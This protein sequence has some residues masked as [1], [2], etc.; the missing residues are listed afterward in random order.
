MTAIRL[1]ASLKGV[2]LRVLA[3]DIS[4]SAGWCL[5][6]GEKGVTPKILGSGTVVNPTGLKEMGKYPWNYIAGA[7]LMTSKLIELIEANTCDVIVIEETNMGRNRY[8]QK[9]LEFLHCLLLDYFKANGYVPAEKVFYIN[10][11]DWRKILGIHM[12]KVDKAQNIKVKRLKRIN[13]EESKAILK[14]AGLRGK[15]T[16]KHLAIRWANETYGLELR[17][18]DDDIADALALGTSYYMGVRFCDG[19]N[20]KRGK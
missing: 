8:S 12:T 4:T 10:T 5:L 17:P 15:M 2:N 19:T 3:L 7:R 18:K 9:I 14:E 20:Q 6:D 1:S 11:S 13:T 16:K